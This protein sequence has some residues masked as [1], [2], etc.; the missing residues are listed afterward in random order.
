MVLL[1]EILMIGIL[2][3]E[4]ILRFWNACIFLAVFLV[5]ISAKLIFF[6]KMSDVTRIRIFFRIMYERFYCIILNIMRC[7]NDLYNMYDIYS[8]SFAQRNAELS[9]LSYMFAYVFIK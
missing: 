8:I 6:Y 2:I 1:N 9:L 7:N 3:C 4:P 5:F